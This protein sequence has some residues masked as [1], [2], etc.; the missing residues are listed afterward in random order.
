MLDAV[1]VF[2]FIASATVCVCLYGTT[3]HFV[4]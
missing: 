1:L 3:N 2:V 4:A